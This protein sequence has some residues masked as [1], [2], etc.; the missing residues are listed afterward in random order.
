MQQRRR[1]RY[2][3]VPILYLFF[4][5]LVTKSVDA[6][7][8]EPVTLSCD[9]DYRVSLNSVLFTN[10]LR[11]PSCSDPDAVAE[12]TPVCQTLNTCTFTGTNV[13]LNSTCPAGTRHR[14]RVNYD[15][16]FG[17]YHLRSHSAQIRWHEA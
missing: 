10:N 15:C 1:Y 4:F 11:R 7:E 9:P 2:N 12:L 17:E 16:L 5:F 14:L 8:D 3:I 13:F 6:W